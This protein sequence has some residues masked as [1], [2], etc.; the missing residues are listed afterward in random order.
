MKRCGGAK[1]THAPIDALLFFLLGLLGSELLSF[2]LPPFELFFLVLEL[3]VARAGG[4]FACFVIFF[5]TLQGQRKKDR[6]FIQ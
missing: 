4:T 5:R 1:R 6:I 3:G 2:I